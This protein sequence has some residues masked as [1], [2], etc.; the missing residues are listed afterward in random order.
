MKS[1][2]SFVILE[3]KLREF[4]TT[5]AT[6]QKWAEPT[7]TSEKNKKMTFGPKYMGDM[8]FW[9]H[10]GLPGL[11]GVLLVGGYG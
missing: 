10:K 6:F 3:P 8:Q 4:S 11:F 7:P 1:A 5:S 2:A 9:A